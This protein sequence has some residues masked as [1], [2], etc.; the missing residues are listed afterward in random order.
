MAD[1][2]PQAMPIR[3]AGAV[4]WRPGADGGSVLLIHRERYSDWTFPKGKREPGE[5][6]LVTAVREVAEETGYRVVLGRP[7]GQTRYASSGHPKVV[8]YWAATVAGPGP[9]QDGPGGAGGAGGFSPNDEVDK[10][11]WVPLAAAPG[12]LSY[13]RDARV[14]AGFAAG[15]PVTV[16]VILLRHAVAGRRQDWRGHDLDRPL[17]ARGAGDADRLAPLLAVFG[18]CDVLSSAAERCVATVRPYAAL[19]GMS[20]EVDPRLAA[21]RGSGITDAQQARAGEAAA[22]GRPV[23]LCAHRENLPGLLAAACARLGAEV[24][25]VRPLRKGAWWVLHAAAGRLAGAEQHAP[26]G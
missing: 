13:E 23:I 26:G 11:E 5:H 7:L 15:P 10:I 9:G 8:D 12:Q 2:R 14:L 20:I 18:R 25:A 4:V 22:A 3:S 21:E 19:T 16:P 24:P 1:R 6:V 17:D